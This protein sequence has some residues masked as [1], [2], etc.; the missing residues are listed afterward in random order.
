MILQ[1]GE[2]ELDNTYQLRMIR[3]NNIPGLLKCSVHK[4]DG[5][6]KLYYEI[7]SKQNLYVLFENRDLNLELFQAIMMGFVRVIEALKEFLLESDHL[8]VDPNYIY[9]NLESKRLYFCYFPVYKKDISKAF[10]EFA[11]YLLT[12]IDHT[13]KQAVVLGYEIY[14]QTMDMNFNLVNVMENLY[15]KTYDKN[16]AIC[17]NNA[18]YGNNSDMSENDY[19]NNDSN[20][21][22]SNKSNKCNKNKSN[23]N[24]S[25]ENKSIEYKNNK[26]KSNENKSSENNNN[27]NINYRSGSIDMDSTPIE[28][29]IE[30]VSVPEGKKEKISEKIGI[31]S[32]FPIKTAIEITFLLIFLY[33][34]AGVKWGLFHQT[35]Y[36][37]VL[38]VFLLILTIIYILI[39]FIDSRKKYYSQSKDYINENSM[40]MEDDSSVEVNL[41]CNVSSGDIQS[42]NQDHEDLDSPKESFGDTT[43]L[44]QI[45]QTNIK[46]LH[47]IEVNNDYVE[48]ILIDK[49]PFCIGKLGP[50]V[51]AVIE[52]KQISRMHARIIKEGEEYYLTDLNSTNGTFLNQLQVMGNDKV[53]CHVGDILYFADIGYEFV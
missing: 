35:I 21:K 39:R 30:K 29:D 11:E 51:D 9:I 4:I 1:I 52:A 43:I 37:A 3:E 14:K 15:S 5:D 47:K 44:M 27:R 26:N 23:E 49:T 22:N 25:N 12:K 31:T 45:P 53:L 18:N 28:D 13:D 7:S 6:M 48:E 16:E 41:E 33:V 2:E 24:K 20:N 34:I 36:L 8:L 32:L 40:E 50:M 42:G 17:D 19:Y 46:K 10:H 38:P